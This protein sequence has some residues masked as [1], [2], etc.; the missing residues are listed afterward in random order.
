MS[1]IQVLRGI[2]VVEQ[3]TFITGPCA[4][5]MLA[6]LGAD[7][8]KIEG[9]E[10]DPY[11]SYQGE[12][13]SPH[14]QAYNRNKRSIACDLKK[15]ADREVFERLVAEAD[16]YLQNFRPG[17]AERLGAGAERLRAL[18][19][20]LIYCSISGFGASGPYAERPSYD[21]VAQALSGFLSVVVDPERPRFLGPALADAITGIYAAYGV[22]G[23]LYERSQ[24]GH[25]TLVEVS[26]LEAMAHFAVEPFAA[27]FALGVTP[28]STDRPRLAQAYILRTADDRLLA[29]HLSSLEKFWQGLTHGA[30]GGRTRCAIRGSTSAWRASITTRRWAKCSTGCFR[31]RPLAEWAERLSAHDV[32]FAPINGID[33]VVDDPQARHLGL[34]VPVE[35]FREGGRYAVRPPL[36]FDGKRATQVSAAP[37]LDQHGSEIRAALSKDKRWPA[38]S[39]ATERAPGGRVKDMSREIHNALSNHAGRQHA[40]ARLADRSAKLAGRF[41][42]RVRAQGTV[43]HPGAVSSPRRRTTPRCSRSRRR[44]KPASTSSPTA[45]SA[46]RAIRTD[47]RPRSR[48][49]ISTIPGT[50]LDRSGHPNPVP[51]VVGPIRR[52]HAVTV[53]DLEFTASSTRHARSRSLSPGPFT[54]SQQAQIDHYGGSAAKA[55]MDYAAAVNEEIRDLFA[56]GADIVQIDEPYM[57]ARPGPARAVRPRSAQSRARRHQADDRRAYLLRLRGDHSRAA[58]APIPFCPSLRA[59]PASRCRSRPRSRISTARSS[60]RS[61]GKKIMLGVHRSRGPECRIAGNRRGA[62][63]SRAA[64]SLHPKNIIVAPDCGMKYLPRDVAF[65]KLK[66][67][68]AGAAPRARGARAARQS[69]TD[70]A[71]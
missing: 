17:T 35:S 3:G 26:M 55:A 59:A 58:R 39:A 14:F 33:S 68:V 29:I 60:R 4:G 67:M 22:L 24:T 6:D 9:P 63:P 19:P 49:S 5:M 27:F 30:R 38:R 12:L 53:A 40:A 66:S 16:V 51:R 10:G 71:H 44:R 23:A 46:A 34:V 45:R 57:Q 64:S 11:R 8:I 62:H 25:G 65:G 70:R 42:P 31:T 61:S 50:A 18:N 21:S 13:Y 69:A 28:K 47:S 54:M 20:R 43:A 1:S 41:P 2:R 32:P 37:L 36:Q 7:V 15:P 48:A 52:K 56:A